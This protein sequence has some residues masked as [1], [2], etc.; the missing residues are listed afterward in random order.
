MLFRQQEC[1]LR[2]PFQPQ[3]ALAPPTPRAP[4]ARFQLPQSERELR[5]CSST[6]LGPPVLPLFLN[7]VLARESFHADCLLSMEKIY[8]LKQYE[9]DGQQNTDNCQS[10]SGDVE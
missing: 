6:F 10:D 7:R 5:F 9:V 2:I 8:G 4:K 1:P 3:I